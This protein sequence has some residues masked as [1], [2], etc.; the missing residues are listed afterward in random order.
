MAKTIQYV[1][2]YK[3]SLREK[4]VYNNKWNI[5]YFGAMFF[6]GGGSYFFA[7]DNFQ[8]TFNDARSM[9]FTKVLMKEL[10]YILIHARKTFNCRV[11]SKML[12]LMYLKTVEKKL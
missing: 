11:S 4:E 8:G 3:V 6:E 12:L 10:A 2:K 5:I 9:M 1:N 7:S